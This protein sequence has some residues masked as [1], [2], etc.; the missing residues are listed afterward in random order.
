MYWSDE[1][2]YLLQMAGTR[3]RMWRQTNSA[4]AD[5][6]IQETIPFGGGSVMGWGCISNDYKLDLVTFKAILMGRDIKR[7]ILETV[8]IPALS[9][10]PVF[11]VDNARP[12]RTRA[13]MDFLQRNAIT[14]IP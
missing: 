1:S 9:T 2:C 14:T 3:T 5:S 6:N 13:V 12:H 7:Y 8:V 10:R 4:F 11:M